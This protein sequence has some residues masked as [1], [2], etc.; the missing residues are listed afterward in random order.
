M[1][2]GVEEFM[3]PSRIRGDKGGEN[4]RIAEYIIQQRGVDRILLSL[5]NLNITQE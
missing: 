2:R 1:K 3:I 5:D 4:V